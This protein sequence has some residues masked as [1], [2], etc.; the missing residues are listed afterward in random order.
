M[1]QSGIDLLGRVAISTAGRDAK[2]AFLV[3]GLS[4]EGYVLLADGRLRKAERPKKKK[5]RHIRLE[6][7]VA[8]DVRDVLLQGGRVA[9]AEIRK[10]LASLGYELE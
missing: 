8:Q 3:V 6:P 1:S 9:D 5:C 4:E 2:R 10:C 7:A